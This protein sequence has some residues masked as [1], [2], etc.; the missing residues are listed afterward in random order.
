MIQDIIRY[1][2]FLEKE[3]GFSV[4]IHGKSRKEN[5]MID[6]LAP[7]N[8]HRNGYCLHVTGEKKRHAVCVAFQDEIRQKSKKHI[9]YTTCPYGVG[10]F[11]VPITYR[12]SYLGFVCVSGYKEEKT[13]V[14]ESKEREL[15]CKIP[16]KEQVAL[17]LCP[18][19]AML[20]VLFTEHPLKSDTESDLYRHILSVIHAGI[21]DKLT[22]EDIAKQCF[23]STSAVSHTF[24]KRSGMTVQ[25]YIRNLRMKRAEEFLLQTELSVMEIA[26][27]C[28][29]SDVNYFIY[30]FGKHKGTSPLQFR[31]RGQIET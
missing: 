10:Q 15:K 21:G 16:E 26:F 11:V 14:F 23:C 18:L 19:A 25:T 3:Y 13:L 20:A 30:A 12:D 4:S 8:I 6:M 2:E 9:F 1:M 22:I 27:R 17:L 31:K 28:G 5:L 29:F 7:Y 24:R